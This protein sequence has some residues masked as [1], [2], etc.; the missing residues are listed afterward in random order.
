MPRHFNAL[1]LSFL[2]LSLLSCC[3][4]RVSLWL[5]PPFT[6]ILTPYTLQ[7]EVR[8]AINCDPEA[9]SGD[10]QEM[11]LGLQRDINSKRI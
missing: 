5:E 6:F 4:Q 7:Y 10:H 2:N 3:I 11:S 9:H 1:P 8:C